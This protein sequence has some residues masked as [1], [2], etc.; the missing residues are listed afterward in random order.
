MNESGKLYIVA[1]P[2]GNLGD[3]SPRAIETLQNV[4]FVAAEDTRVT[5]K[6]LNHFQIKKHL[7][8]CQKYNE[9]ERAEQIISR[10]KMGENCANYMSKGKMAAVDGQLTTRSYE[11][12]DGHKVKV[13]EVVADQ[14]RFLSPKNE[15]P[16]NS[17]NAGSD[18]EM[19]F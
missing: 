10:I 6:L 11:A 5:G 3:L 12:K 14:V 13:Y 17:F 15:A 4:D 9:I 16:A 19:P 2:I 1:T 18:E 7:V 8:S